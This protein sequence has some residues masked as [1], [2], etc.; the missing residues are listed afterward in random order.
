MRRRHTGAPP[1]SNWEGPAI[2]LEGRGFGPSTTPVV[3]PRASSSGSSGSDDASDTAPDVDSD[4]EGEPLPPPPTQEEDGPVL[5]AATRGLLL[6][7]L[8]AAAAPSLLP[9]VTARLVMLCALGAAAAVTTAA[10]AMP[11]GWVPLW[12]LVFAGCGCAGA[13]VGGLVGDAV[14]AMPQTQSALRWLSAALTR[15][16]SRA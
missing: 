6:C 8:C 5:R 4:G 11:R 10:L 13:L 16:V 14:K 2:S 15:G 7:A 3:R 1:T 9:G 12:L